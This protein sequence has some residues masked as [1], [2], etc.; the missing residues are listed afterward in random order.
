MRASTIRP[1]ILKR[2]TADFS[3]RQHDSLYNRAD[4]YIVGS[5][6]YIGLSR[7]V[8]SKQWVEVEDFERFTALELIALWDGGGRLW[9]DA[10]HHVWSSLGLELGYVAPVIR[11]LT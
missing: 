11:R 9:W 2:R 7:I 1:N 4:F 6:M 8:G 3:H 10:I 5:T